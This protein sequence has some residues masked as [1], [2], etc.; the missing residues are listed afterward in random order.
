MLKNIWRSLLCCVLTLCINPVFA[1][2]QPVAVITR[3]GQEMDGTLV[4]FFKQTIVDLGPA[5]N[6]IPPQGW[7]VGIAGPV[8]YSPSHVNELNWIPGNYKTMADGKKTFAELAM[9][10][11]K[12]LNAKSVTQFYATNNVGRCLAYLAAPLSSVG[13][14]WTPA[15]YIM[16][17]GCP[18]AP[19][20]NLYCRF[21]NDQIELDHKTVTNSKVNGNTAQ[22]SLEVSCNA[23]STVKF[24]LIG[25]DENIYLQPSGQAKIQINNMP[26]NSAINLQ[27]GNN[28]LILKDELSGIER[29]GAYS[30][31]GVL[32]IELY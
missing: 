8:G 29:E 13:Q 5:G 11:Y 27:S 1:T 31:S 20:S 21:V 22:A 7:Y 23:P 32:I 25:S 4:I 17:Q 14:W 12:D 9:Y 30:G 28:S 16:P 2:S 10:V 6:Q 3:I 19:P 24:H 15:N 26:L 18:E